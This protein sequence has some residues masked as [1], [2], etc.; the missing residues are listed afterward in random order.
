MVRITRCFYGFWVS[1]TMVV[2]AV[3]VEMAFVRKSWEVGGAKDRNR[4]VAAELKAVGAAVGKGNGGEPLASCLASSNLA[5]TNAAG[6]S[7]PRCEAARFYLCCSGSE[8]QCLPGVVHCLLNLLIPCCLFGPSITFLK[9]KL[10]KL[11]SLIFL[12]W[13]VCMTEEWLIKILEPEVLRG[14]RSLETT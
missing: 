7:N 6:Q 11:P 12:E 1:L 14:N 3:L 9:H 2:P 13:L 10:S 8:Y 4:S 5:S